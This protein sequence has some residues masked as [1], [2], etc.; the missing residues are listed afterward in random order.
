MFPVIE[1]R[2]IWDTIHRKKKMLI[3]K[4]YKLNNGIMILPSLPGMRIVWYV[5]HLKNKKRT[6]DFRLKRK[7]EKKC[8]ELREKYFGKIW[9]K[10]NKL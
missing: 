4:N 7:Y 10:K 5:R 8:S 3:L 9:I 1:R 2:K 6:N